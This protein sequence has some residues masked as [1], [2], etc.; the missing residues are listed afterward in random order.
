MLPIILAA[1]ALGAMV[2]SN[3]SIS[4]QVIKKEPNA[5]DPILPIDIKKPIEPIK[6]DPIKVEP[7]KSD[8]IVVKPTPIVGTKPVDIESIFTDIVDASISKSSTTKKGS[9]IIGELDK[10]SYGERVKK[11]SLI[12]P[13]LDKGEFVAD[14]PKLRGSLIIPPLD[15]GSFDKPK[16]KGTIIIPP[17]ESITKKGTDWETEK[18]WGQQITIPV[19]IL[20]NQRKRYG[21]IAEQTYSE[22]GLGD[23]GFGAKSSGGSGGGVGGGESLNTGG[24]FNTGWGGLGDFGG[25]FGGGFGGGSGGGGSNKHGEII[26]G[27]LYQTDEDKAYTESTEQT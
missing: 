11:G 27:D 15:K 5:I 9:L 7:I 16:R 17:I 8:P 24:G 21:V 13:P 26:I 20:T 12:I 18:P 25:F 3:K 6:S 23:A 19:P 14:K 4:K 2:S 1:A 22:K 10:G